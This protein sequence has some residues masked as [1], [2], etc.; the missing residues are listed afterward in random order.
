[1]IFGL[2]GALELGIKSLSV[3]GDSLLVINQI[4]GLYKVKSDSLLELHKEAVELK[5]HFDYIEFNHVY[6]EN[7]KR[8][9]E[10]SNL[11]LENVGDLTKIEIPLATT[12]SEFIKDLDEDWVEE[13]KLLDNKNTKTKSKSKSK[14]ITRLCE[15]NSKQTTITQ[16]FKVNAFLP[17]I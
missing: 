8:A 5:T 7:N 6:R 3:Y 15:K 13:I 17:D 14:K 10:L 1:L 9:D 4:T 12:T 2:K 16:L 11:A